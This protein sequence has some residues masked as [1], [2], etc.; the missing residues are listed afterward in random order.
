MHTPFFKQLKRYLHS[1]SYLCPSKPNQSIYNMNN[2]KRIV[3]ADVLRLVAIFMVVCSHCADPF[4]VSPEA[5]SNPE[6]NFWGSLY[7]T[8]LRPCVPLFVMLTGLLLLPVHQE[9]GLFYRKRITRV[10]IPFLIWSVFYNLFPWLTKIAGLDASVVS[11]MFAYAGASPDRSAADALH[12]VMLIPLNFS[13]Y[14]THLWY[15]YMLIGLYLFMPLLSAWYERASQRQVRVVLAL[16]GVSLF[17]PYC[18]EY[19]STYV[20]GECAWNDFGVLYYFSG[21]TGY[22]LLGRVL[23]DWDGLSLGRTVL[24]SL[25]LFAVGYAVTYYGFRVVT[26]RPDASERQVELFFLY[27]SPNVVAMTL[28]WFLLVRKVRSLPARLSALLRNLTKCGLGVYMIH[29]FV[30]GLG[31]RLVDVLSIPVSL[32]IPVAAVCVFAASWAV[33]ALFYKWRPGIAR[34]VMG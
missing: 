15:I 20:G 29:Y 5:R 27:C 12:R 9:S 10:A 19:V 13:I 2:E 3:W 32:R 17:L 33:V 11:D 23:R 25:V 24:L 30:V 4:N 28:S 31:Y 7:G 6:F 14:T 18:R 1:V 26:A 8:F 21:F 22:L 16:W 34:W